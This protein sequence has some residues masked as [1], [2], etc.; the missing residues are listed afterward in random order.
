MLDQYGEPGGA[1]Q[2][3]LDLLPAIVDRRWEATVAAPAGPLL[4]RASVAGAHVEAI[5]F[6][7][8]S[9]GRKG[10][11]DWL[12]FAWQFPPLLRRIQRILD[13]REIDIVYVN[14]PRMVPVASYD[15]E[16]RRA[17]FHCHSLF[18]D[19]T[20]LVGRR[21]RHMRATVIAN[22]RHVA[23]PLTPWVEDARMHTVHNGVADMAAPRYPRQGPPRIGVIGR[24]S[25]EKG[26]SILLEATRGLDSTLVICGAPLFSYPAYERRLREAARGRAVEFLP[27]SGDMRAV[28]ASLDVVAVPSVGTEAAT[29]VIPEVFSAGVPVV[30]FAT[31]GIPEIVEDE[32]TGL[33]APE[34]TAV[35]LANRLAEVEGVRDRLVA[36]ARRAYEERFTLARWRKSIVGVLQSLENPHVLRRR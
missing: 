19:S 6:G 21:L 14:G 34:P 32:V 22:C 10:P 13:E 20:D 31:G 5:R 23:A 8:F 35:A 11:V 2:C 15:R 26:Q 25:P 1:Q 3:L 9:S 27:W 30:A 12:R 29:R 4:E 16:P 18:P 17:V 33:L 7:P 24:L 28:Y 36:N